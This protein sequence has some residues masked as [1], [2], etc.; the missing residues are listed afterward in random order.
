MKKQKKKDGPPLHE[1]VT[2]GV[3]VW[4]NGAGNCIAR[5]GV[6][7]IDIHKEPSRQVKSGNECLF[8]THA[9][10]TRED[11]DLFV[12]KMLELYKISITP[13]FLPKRFR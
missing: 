9:P 6:M 7:G 5:F 8:C 3:T 1:V 2:D 4:V 10:T 13:R 12:V 11:W